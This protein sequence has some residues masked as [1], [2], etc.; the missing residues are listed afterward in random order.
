MP[1]LLGHTAPA[2]CLGLA[3]GRNLVPWRLLIVGVLFAILPDLDVLG[4][5]FGVRYADILGHRGLSHSLLAALLA[6][7][8]GFLTAPFL[9]S[10][11]FTAFLVCGGAVATHILLDAMTDGG[12]GVAVFWPWSEQRYFL[13]WRPIAV[14]PFSLERLLSSSGVRVFAS[15]LRWVWLPCLAAGVLIVCI[16]ALARISSR[17]T[18]K[19]RHRFPR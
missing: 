12:L 18:A 2:L 19:E 15:E 16:R 8:I 4:F 14:S 1:T 3:C 13:P 9:R 17:R 5:R 7:L 10:G 11:R 6:G